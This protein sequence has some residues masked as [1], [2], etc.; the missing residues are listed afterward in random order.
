MAEGVTT[1]SRNITTTLLRRI[2]NGTYAAGD[3]LPTERKLMEE[4]GVTRSVIREALKRVEALGY[5][6]IRQ[7]SG[8]FVEP[9]QNSEID[10]IY[11]SLFKDDGKPDKTFIRDLV[12]FHFVQIRAVVPLA[13]ERIT[14]TQLRVLRRLARERAA[15]SADRDALVDN[16]LSV[17]ALIVDASHNK[18]YSLLYGTLLR[19]T[20]LFQGMAEV[21]AYRVDESQRFFDSIVP[22]FES[23]DADTAS[24]VTSTMLNS[25]Y[26]DYLATVER[27]TREAK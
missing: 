7:G 1:V 8:I 23:G 20:Y 24:R 2:I 13:A 26:R 17:A 12:E 4:F 15:N 27:L 3:K 22:A 5:L 18:Y 11:L 6:S 21:F 19:I 16:F 9:V 14:Q 10:V 25:I